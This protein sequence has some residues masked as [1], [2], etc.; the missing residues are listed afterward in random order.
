MNHRFDILFWKPS[1]L[2]HWLE[3]KPVPSVRAPLPAAQGPVRAA[4]SNLSGLYN[5]A[6]EMLTWEEEI[7]GYGGREGSQTLSALR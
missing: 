5:S 1:Q 4:P 3:A 2:E 7:G 6:R